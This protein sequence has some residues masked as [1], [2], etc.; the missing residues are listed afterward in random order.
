MPA[1]TM[2]TWERRIRWITVHHEGS[3]FCGDDRRAVQEIQKI[4]AWHKKKN[5]GSGK[6]FVGA[7]DIA[8]HAVINPSTGT[9]F[10]TNSV[11]EVTWHDSSNVDSVGV[12]V[13][14]DGR[15]QDWTRHVDGAL[16]R[17]LGKWSKLLLTWRDLRGHRDV[18]ATICPGDKYYQGLLF[19]KQKK[20]EEQNK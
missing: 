2:K 12:L 6:A 10:Y 1:R 11:N 14:G 3:Y 7:P 8:Y 19:F 13:L 15:V 5:W 20:D 18:K 4:R 16:Q 17:I 9:V